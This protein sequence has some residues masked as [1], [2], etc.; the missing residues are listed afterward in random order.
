MSTRRTRLVLLAVDG[1][2]ALAAIGG[3]ATMLTGLDKFP[4]AWL[5]GTPFSSYVIPGLLLALFVGG[6]AAVATATL[7]V[8]RN[9][10]GQASIVAGAVLM[11]WLVG[12]VLILKQPSAPSPT[13][14]FFF[15]IGLIMLA[16]GLNVAWSQRQRQIQ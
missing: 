2:V 11:G 9:W 3:G 14:V 4:P 5:E 10:S 12:E 7:L 6:S 13:E 16:L 1:L 15:V 8:A